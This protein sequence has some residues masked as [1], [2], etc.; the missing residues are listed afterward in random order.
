MTEREKC[1]YMIFLPIIREKNQ[2]KVVVAFIG[3]DIKI[4]IRFSWSDIFVIKVSV[5]H[6]FLIYV[7]YKILTF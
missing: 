1:V 2:A 7:K 3:L 6:W 5:R 4:Y